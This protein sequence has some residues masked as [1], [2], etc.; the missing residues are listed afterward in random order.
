MLSPPE[1]PTPARWAPALGLIPNRKFAATARAYELAGFTR[2]GEAAPLVA[3]NVEFAYRYYSRLA[4]LRYAAT[5]RQLLASVDEAGAGPLRGAVARGAGVLLVS[6]HLGDFDVAGSWLAQVLGVEVV[7]V[8]DPVAEAAR[9]RWFDGVRRASGVIL[10]RRGATRLKDVEGDLRRGR[11]VLFMLDRR[12]PGPAVAGEL[13]GRPAL[14]PVAPYVLARRTGAEVVC[15]TTITRPD[16][17]R[18]LL[19][20]RRPALDEGERT[21][22]AFLGPLAD[23]LTRHLSCCPWQWHIPA[24]LDQL[25]WVTGH[26]DKRAAPPF[27]TA[28]YGAISGRDGAT[29]AEGIA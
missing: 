15:G 13:L 14:L 2:P 20:E 6:A 22:V 7:V 25:A 16:G 8:L 5:R 19:T 1:P 11:V 3:A 21:A 10:R 4:R 26:V 9:Q 27:C 29:S 24:R 17:R 12:T 18:E 23:A 28:S